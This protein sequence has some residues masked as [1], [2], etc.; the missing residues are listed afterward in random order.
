VT[1]TLIETTNTAKARMVAAMVAAFAADPAVRWLYPDLDQYQT[2]F[3]DFVRAF[4]GK[5]FACDTAREVEGVSS[6][7]LWLPPGAQ[8]DE[9]AIV[10]VIQRSVSEERL[11]EVFTLFEQM[12]AFHPHEPHWYLPMIGVDPLAQGR[13]CG[14]AL[15]SPV[16]KQCD[17]DGLPAYLESTNP[18][19]ISLYERFNFKPVGRIQTRTSPPII[20]MFRH[21]QN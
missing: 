6:A 10:D 18:R 19:N 4:G 2:H 1:A 7:A 8:P 3:P 15:L 17:R 14:T 5:A 13:G 11:P 21:P 16:L 9:A 20:P 12:G